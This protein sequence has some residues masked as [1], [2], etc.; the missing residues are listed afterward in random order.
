MVESMVALVL[1]DA[2]MAQISQCEMSDFDE[3]KPNPLGMGR[4]R[5]DWDGVVEKVVEGGKGVGVGV[6]LNVDEE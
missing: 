2:L 3:E 1:V 6:G 4:Q 5:E